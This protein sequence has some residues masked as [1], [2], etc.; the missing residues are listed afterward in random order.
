ML[1]KIF[2]NDFLKNKIV[3][4]TLFIFILSSAALTASAVNMAVELVHSLRALFINTKAPHFVQMHTGKIDQNYINGWSREN[5]LVKNHQIVEMLTVDGSNIYLGNGYKSEKNSVMNHYFVKQNNDFDFLLDL[6]NKIIQVNKGEVAVPIY[7]MQ[8][9]K[10]HIGD[11]IRIVTDCFN[12]E[13]TVAG[14]VRDVQ[15]NPSVVHSKRFVLNKDDYNV[16]KAHIGSIKYLIE[17]QLH[18]VSDINKFTNEYQEEENLP[19]KGPTLNYNLY[20][21]LN[22]MTDGITIAIIILIGFLLS[23]II[24]LCLWFTILASMEED[25]REIGIMKAIGIYGYDIKKLYLFKYV[26]MAAL[27]SIIGYFISLPCNSLFTSNIALYI[28]ISP[29]SV[30]R[31]VVSFLAV[32]ILFLFIVLFC[33]FTLRCFN[34][35]TVME[36][37]RKASIGMR[38]TSKNFFSLYKRGFLNVNVFLGLLDVLQRFKLFILPFLVFFVCTFIVTVPINFY[39]TVKS[40]SFINYMG[41]GRSDIRIDLQYAD[42]ID[43]RFNSIISYIKTDKDV[44]CFS[45][46]ATFQY[47]IINSNGE[48]ENINIESGDFS[49][50]SVQYLRGHFPLQN[51]EIALSYL[52]SK[53]WKKNVGD[54]IKLMVGKQIRMMTVS[55]IYQDVTNG[56][57]TAKALLP[58]DSRKALWYIMNLDIKKHVDIREKVHEY[59]RLFYPAK[60]TSIEDYLSQT[61]GD[62]IKQLRNIAML[63]TVIAIGIAVLITSLFLKMLMAK[64]Y[65]QIAIMKNIGLSFKDIRLQ[66]VVKI[67]FVAF[68]GLLL[69]I[70][71]AKVGGQS[72]VSALWSSMGAS[73]IKFVIISWQIYFLCPFILIFTVMVTTLVSTMVIKKRNNFLL[74]EGK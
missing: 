52:N 71:A 14:F 11:K 41:V 6:H 35:I 3:V 20:E 4:I 36:A 47:K 66:Y 7:Y 38:C 70:I 49:L 5:S 50:F 9:N 43:T 34:K 32:V 17:F 42:N 12:E 59:A 72:V 69:G 2:K 33:I 27:A 74:Q 57:R 64:D 28:G 73:E 46:L 10:M 23:I 31:Y 62:L 61:L 67:T 21:I 8:R 54:Q 22:A 44:K 53:E 68:L 39:N 13:F 15:M 19:K 58:S 56:G 51:N 37:L 18:D 1:L 65:L 48:L 24:G 16:L 25:Y 40:P 45:P 63:A 29:A 60:V 26:F 30:F 55:G